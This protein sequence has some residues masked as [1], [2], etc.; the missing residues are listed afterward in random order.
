MANITIKIVKYEQKISGDMYCA[1]LCHKESKQSII[2][3]YDVKPSGYLEMCERLNGL[4]IR[5]EELGNQVTTVNEYVPD[6]NF[7]TDEE[8]E[9]YWQK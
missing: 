6:P 5:L 3:A 7:K 2:V 4:R 9:D 8:V 1:Y